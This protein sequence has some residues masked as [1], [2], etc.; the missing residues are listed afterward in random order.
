MKKAN[1]FTARLATSAA[2]IMAFDPGKAGWKLDAD[3]KIE[4]K[5][6]QPIYVQS[7]G[8]EITIGADTVSRLNGEAKQYREERD[9]ARTELKKFEKITD[10]AKAL[11]AMETVAKIDQKKLIDAGEVDKVRSEIENS[12][13]A[14]I[15]ERDKKINE[16]SGQLNSMTLSQAFSASE[17]VRDKIAVPADMFRSTFEKNFK[18]E[19]GKVVAYGSDGNKLYSKQRAGELASF[20][21]A[22]ELLVDGYSHRDSILKADNHQGTGNKGGGGGNPR[23]RRMTRS[24]F[25]ALGPVAQ[26]ENA[27]LATKGELVITD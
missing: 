13:K 16:Q 4:L 5:D 9:A 2:A 12:F 3:G 17:F 6:G 10:P 19:D 11:A 8:T 18:V 1:L 25:D 23:A 7:D 24:E 14:Q 27:A 21:E 15:E 20:D 22:L 26:A